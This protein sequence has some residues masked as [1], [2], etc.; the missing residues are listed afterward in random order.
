MGDYLCCRYFRDVC[1]VWIPHEPVGMKKAPLTEEE[2]ERHSI[3][4]RERY[5]SRLAENAH[6]IGSTSS[7]VRG[8]LMAE[9]RWRPLRRAQDYRRLSG[10]GRQSNGSHPIRTATSSPAR[11]LANTATSS[12]SAAEELFRRAHICEFGRS[13]SLKD[14]DQTSRGL[15]T[16]CPRRSRTSRCS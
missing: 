1:H 2:Q 16:R 4:I 14:K 11:R 7:L 9:L 8:N 12:A 5:E 10:C 3:F 13:D 6:I 15:R